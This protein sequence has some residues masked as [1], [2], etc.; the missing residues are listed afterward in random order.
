MAKRRG[1]LYRRGGKTRTKRAFER[2]YEKRGYSKARADR[3]YGATVGKVRREQAAEHGGKVRERVRGHYATRNGHRY[4]VRAHTAIIHAERHPRGHH[5]GR[6]GT[7]C[8]A[9]RTTH[10]HPG[11]RHRRHR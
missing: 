9:G 7:S 1:H 6:C 3:I 10:Y 4:R 8:R 11:R 5:K 2:R